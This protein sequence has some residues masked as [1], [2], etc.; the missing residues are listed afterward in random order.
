VEFFAR[1][2]LEA[3]YVASLLAGRIERSPGLPRIA[4]G[5]HPELI[6]MVPLPMDWEAQRVLLGLTC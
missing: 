4:R 1:L 6:R 3:A 5:D 2:V